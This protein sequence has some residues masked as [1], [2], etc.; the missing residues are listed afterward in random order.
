MNQEQEKVF[1]FTHRG[2][3]MKAPHGV[4]AE[5]L[6]EHVRG[7][8]LSSLMPVFCSVGDAVPKLGDVWEG[9]GGIRA[10]ECRAED[11]GI[12]DLV[13]V[14]G[15]D[16]KPLILKDREWGC[17]GSEIA[18]ES[19]RDGVVNTKAMAEAGSQL[20]KDIV[21]VKAEGNTDCYLPALCELNQVF[22]N[23]GHLLEKDV[24]W[25]STQFSAGYAW[26]QAFSSGTTNT[27]DK[28]DSYRALV[29]RRVWR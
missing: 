22:A 20:A 4:V 15:A 11:G 24:Y 29:V 7:P 28:N 12:Y 9:Q 19:L 26:G 6:M 14:T 16:G 10:A 23:M 1:E 3:A 21:A 18:A 27:W 17:R 25:S 2:V 5:A 8:R 13:L